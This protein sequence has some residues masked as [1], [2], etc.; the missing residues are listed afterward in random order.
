VK[1]QAQ[2]NCNR[3]NLYNEL[4][5]QI[6]AL[7]PASEEDFAKVT[8][9]GNNEFTQ[10]YL[11]DDLSSEDLK[12]AREIIEKHNPVL[13]STATRVRD[14]SS[15]AI[16]FQ[17]SQLNQSIIKP[18][19]DESRNPILQQNAVWRLSDDIQYII[20]LRVFPEDTKIED[21]RIA[22]LIQNLKELEAKLLTS[23][24]LIPLK[25]KQELGAALKKSG[26]GDVAESIGWIG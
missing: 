20:S 8:I 6:P 18:I 4:M 12:K 2:K 23:G 25:A 9:A 16:A 17:L 5:Q 26:F 14:W 22:N 1:T 24:V 10:V 15:L 3:A 7:S 13:T 21:T 11:P 19:K